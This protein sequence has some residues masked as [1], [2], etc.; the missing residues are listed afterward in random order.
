[1][2]TILDLRSSLELNDTRLQK[3]VGITPIA[4]REKKSYR[5]LF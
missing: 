2:I 5:A 4:Y 3:F 1:M